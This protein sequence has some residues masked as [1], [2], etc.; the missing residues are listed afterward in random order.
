MTGS[1]LFRFLDLVKEFEQKAKD[2]KDQDGKEAG[3]KAHAYKDA[4]KKVNDLLH[5]L[6]P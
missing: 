3:A 6:N 4:A 2:L 1:E 5:E